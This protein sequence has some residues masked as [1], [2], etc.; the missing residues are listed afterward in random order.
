MGE[1]QKKSLG[2]SAEGIGKLIVID[3]GENIDIPSVSRQIDTEYWF[4][5]ENTV[6]GVSHPKFILSAGNND[7]INVYSIPR[8]R[9]TAS[10]LKTQGMYPIWNW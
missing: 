6:A 9:A 7:W 10:I 5:E 3:S 4:Y 1:I 8:Y 2:L